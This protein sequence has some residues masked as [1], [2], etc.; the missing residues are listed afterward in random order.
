MTIEQ[1][2][3]E[4]VTDKD[5]KEWRDEELW[6][7]REEPDDYEINA[8]YEKLAQLEDDITAGELI[9]TPRSK[10]LLCVWSN[11]LDNP[12]YFIYESRPYLVKLDDKWYPAVSEDAPYEISVVVAVCDTEKEAEDA[13]QAIKVG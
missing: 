7:V 2:Y 13:L 4:R 8:V 1:Y 5:W 9:R 3:G 11:T 12:Q 10:W 6:S